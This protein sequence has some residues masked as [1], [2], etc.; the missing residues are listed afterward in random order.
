MGYIQSYTSQVQ[1]V[2]STV[3][4]T[5]RLSKTGEMTYDVSHLYQVVPAPHTRVYVYL[6]IYIY[7]CVYIY[8]YICIYIYIYIYICIYII[9]IYNSLENS[10][11]KATR[12]VLQK[13]I[14]ENSDPVKVELYSL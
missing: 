2:L 10:L 5:A 12:G 8:I 3:E 13:I 9:H 7:I 11:E 1:N 4:L 14:S 6:Y